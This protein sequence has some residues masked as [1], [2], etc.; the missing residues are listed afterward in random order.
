MK[1]KIY[2][3]PMRTVALLQEKNPYVYNL[4]T[5]LLTNFDIVN[6]GKKIK[7]GVLDVW[8]YL[9]KA[10][11]FYF[12]WIEDVSFFQAP[13][14]ISFFFISKLLGKRI[15]WTHHNRQPHK[16]GKW[17]NIFIIKL[18]TK[19]ADFIIVHTDESYHILNADRQNPRIKYFFHPFFT[20][21]IEVPVQTE[22]KYDLL[23]WGTIRKSKGIEDFM[24]YLLRSEKTDLYKIKIIGRFQDVNYYNEFIH[25]YNGKFIS[26]ENNFISKEELKILHQ[27]A[28]Y[29][30]FPY[31]G[32]SVLNSGALI[33]SLP[34]GTPIIGPNVGAFKEA[35]TKGLIY[36]YGDFKDVLD[37]VD[38]K[39]DDLPNFNSLISQ[40]IKKYT[41]DNFSLYLKDELNKHK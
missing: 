13:F 2:M 35:S 31:T 27:E 34:L 30:F 8:K 9:F 18:L 39:I 16:A 5:A 23:I 14:F 22:K 32:L 25:R 40:Y 26:I 19:Y 33:T 36:S 29:I 15:I 20:R 21:T 12:N 38:H 24:E 11:Y 41:W 1:D 3:F 7:G 37:Y 4:S 28:K 10:K 17:I 6:Y